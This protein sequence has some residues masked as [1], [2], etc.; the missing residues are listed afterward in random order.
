MRG[1]ALFVT[2]TDTGVG[3]TW[4]SVQLLREWRGRGFR[5][6]G[7]KAAE[8]GCT[9]GP[10]GLR[11]E[12]DEALFEAAGAWQPERCRYRFEP[13]V[14][15]GV[16]AEDAGVAL[17]FGAIAAQVERLIGEAARVIVEGAGG[18]LAPMGEGRTVETLAQSLALDVLIVGRAG[19]GTISH[20]S[21]TARAVAAAGL[22]VAGVLLSVRPED[23]LAFAERN[24]REISRLV[25]APVE[26]L[27]SASSAIDRLEL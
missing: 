9:Q 23:D 26:L 7:L 17:D 25:D 14:A 22:R 27:G 12:D 15:P 8:S 1:R 6:A 16:A 21:L 2:G 20:A 11:G 13:A 4:A 24:R 18:W 19:L 5:V 10:A 3:K